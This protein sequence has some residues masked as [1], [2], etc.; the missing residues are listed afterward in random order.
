MPN[1]KK[2]VTITRRNLKQSRSRFLNRELFTLAMELADHTFKKT[3]LASHITFI[4]RSLR[5]RVIP[6]RF[7]VR[8]HPADGHR[9]NRR[10]SR[11][12]DSCS[13]RLMQATIQNLKIQLNNISTL[14]SRV[15]NHFHDECASAEY[16]RALT[17]ILEKNSELHREI[18]SIKDAKFAS[19][20]GEVPFN[21]S[22]ADQA[23]A[24]TLTRTVVT[25][26]DD[27]T[28]NDA[29]T[30]VLSKGL[31]FVPVN[32]TTDEYE[33]RADCERYFRRLRLKAHFHDREEVNQEPDAD[34]PFSKFNKKISTWTPL[35][36]KFSAL[37][38]YIDRCRRGISSQ[39]YTRRT[40]ITNLSQEEQ[41]AIRELRGRSN[42]VVKP[43]DKGG[44]VVVWSR[45]LYIQ[46]ANRQLSDDRFYQ[47]LEADPTQDYQKIVKDTLKDMVATCE[48]P[49]TA[50]HLVVTTP[51]TSRFYILPKIHKPGNPGGPIVSAC[52]CPTENI[53]AYLEE[54]MA[55]FVR[56]LP[57]YIKDTNHALRVFDSFSFDDMDARSRFLFTMGIKSLYTVIPNDGGLEALAHF[58]DQRTNKEPP[59][60][61]LTRLAELLLTL[62]AFS[63]NGQ[64][65]RQTGGVAMGTKMGPNYACLFVGFVEEQIYANYTGFLPQL[66]KRYIDDVV[67]VA[68]CTRLELEQFIDYVCNFHPALQ[69]NIYH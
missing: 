24:P 7:R 51:R 37:D 43:A 11:I 12:T 33:V 66:H 26:P 53:S 58:L 39:N 48:L 16:N 57:T 44:A 50:Q 34:D 1:F 9:H 14:K 31:T 22:T 63:F 40:N 56:N 65:Y 23:R 29:E 60:H 45:D 4:G 25:I 21:H 67:G 68:Q 19:L 3:K 49:P 38:H 64:H 46:E 69:V 13:R 42:I 52:S 62:N 8:F 10:L 59:T 20:R 36:G 54:V 5:K 30:S 47:R 28:L 32:N 35:N 61:T 2:T 41:Q 15:C 17:L 55:P 6:K 27:L 18:K